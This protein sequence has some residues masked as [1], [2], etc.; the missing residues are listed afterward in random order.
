VIPATCAASGCTG[1]T[2]PGAFFI[3]HRAIPVTSVVGY[4]RKTRGRVLNYSEI[5]QELFQKDAGVR[6]Y[7]HIPFCVRKCLYCDFLSMPQGEETRERYVNAL[8]CEIMHQGDCP[9]GTPVETIFFGGGTPSILEERQLDAILDA[10][11][12]RFCVPRD[13]EISLE[14]NPGTADS[15]KLRAMRE[16]GI[17]RLSIGV[18]AMHDGELK[19]LGRIHTVEE[20]RE[21]FQLA[22]KAGFENINIDLM[23]ALPGQTFR[24]WSDTLA[25][26]VG[27]G[28]EHISAYSLII[29]P[30]TPF[31]AMYESG[32]LPPVPEEETDRQMYHFTGEYLA[33]KGYR[34]YEISNYAKPGRACRHN[35]GYW[36]G[37]E[38]LGFGIGAAS[39]AGGMRFSNTRDLQEYIRAMAIPDILAVRTDLHRLTEREKMEE[40]MFLGLRMTA[41]VSRTAFASRF[42]KQIEDVYG[43]VLQ[44][45]IRQGVI[46][47][48]EDGVRLTQRGVDVSNYVLADYLL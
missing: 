10:L 34:Q 8:L 15:E 41:G 25:E 3:H 1:G 42:G 5:M 17:N 21:A 33:G 37:Q 40:F 44:K 32:D 22:R 43:E 39:C 36:T 7:L 11:H 19:L 46:I 28:P 29:E 47:P 23:S 30:G 27:W 13:A 26:A 45:Q 35:T 14:M 48:T 38:Y 4:V 6:I 20:A 16:M 12:E 24:D 31:S 18:Q 2:A 9:P